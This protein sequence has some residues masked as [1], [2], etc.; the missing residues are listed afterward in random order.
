[1]TGLTVGEST[2]LAALESKIA[3]GLKTFIEVGEA[4]ARIRDSRLYRAQ[5]GTFEDYCRER[6][7]F[8]S[9]RARQLIG[10]AETV[11]NLESVTTVTLLPST[12]SQARPLTTL[13]PEQ[14]REAW[15]RAVETAPAG[16]VTA[17]HVE[18]VVAEMTTTAMPKL[19]TVDK[20][21][22]SNNSGNNEWYTPPEYIAAARQVMGG[23]DLDPASSATANAIVQAETFYT[24]NEDG[25]AWDWQGRLWL[26]PP[27]AQP[28]ITQFCEKLVDEVQLGMISQACV[29]VN[30]ATD[31]RWG[32]LLVSNA[33]A[34]CFVKGRVRF[35]DMDGNPSGA[36]LQ[37]QM[38]AYFGK[39]VSD[40]ANAFDA[41]GVVLCAV[42]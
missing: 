18:A 21:H 29:L 17:A 20:P 11:R 37:G 42:K 28:L 34:V 8:N 10:A 40:F 1:M 26:N 19:V 15:Q 12:E 33:A 39:N 41:F 30:N 14:Q 25:L 13:E 9:S 6:W 23:I 27:Y 2:E 5:F 32:Q 22:V 35:L 7:G 4:L 3:A 38:V 31:T 24:E 36:P 16:K